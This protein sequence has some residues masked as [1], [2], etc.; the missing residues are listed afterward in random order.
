MT[1]RSELPAVHMPKVRQ[2]QQPVSLAVSAVRNA[3]RTVRQRQLQ[4]RISVHISIMI[5]VQAVA[6][7][8]KYARDMSFC[9]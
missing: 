3:R 2:L 9:K 5:N 7:V 1:N 4:L 8:R 6:N